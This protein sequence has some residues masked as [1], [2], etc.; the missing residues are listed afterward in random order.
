VAHMAARAMFGMRINIF[1]DGKQVR[2]ILYVDDLIEAYLSAVGNIDKV[3]G[4][5]FNIGG[6]EKNAVSVA[7]YISFLESKLGVKIKTKY[8]PTRPGDQKYFVSDNGK[9]KKFISWIPKTGYT[10][11]VRKMIGWIGE[12]RSL[13][14]KINGNG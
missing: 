5:V 4:E 7:G 11:G 10:E 12:N 3:K 9:I 6:G 1:G 2:D 14:E 8:F 13:F